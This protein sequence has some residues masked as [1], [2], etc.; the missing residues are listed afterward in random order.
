[1]TLVHGRTVTE[2]LAEVAWG[3]LDGF[4]AGW[5]ADITAIDLLEL[6]EPRWRPVASFPLRG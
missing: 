4:A 5:R 6:I 3:E 2:E 1:M